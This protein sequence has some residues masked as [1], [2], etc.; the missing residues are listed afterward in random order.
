MSKASSNSDFASLVT[1]IQKPVEIP[2]ENFTPLLAHLMGAGTKANGF[3][4]SEIIPPQDNNSNEWR[5]VQR[6][7]SADKLEDWKNSPAR[8]EVL[9]VF[10]QS[11]HDDKSAQIC[12]EII[13]GEATNEV[14]T[15]IFTDLKP[16]MEEEYFAWELKMQSTQAA[17]PGYLGIHI[18]P[19]TSER[20]GRWATLLRFRSPEALDTWFSSPE[21]AQLLDEKQRFV[22]ATEI[23]KVD[24]SFPGWFAVD[25]KGKSPPN[26][27]TAQLVLLGIFPIVML[28]IKFCNP[29]YIEL[30]QI[31]P[32]IGN[33]LNMMMSCSLVA[34]V[35]MPQFIKIF[36]FWLYPPTRTAHS[37]LM[38]ELLVLTVLG[39]EIL[40]LWKLL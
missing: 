5:L 11:L 19:P 14:A 39:I 10:E 30:N 31:S 32:A 35:T 23:Q 37:E 16:G 29:H 24:S 21:R 27:K 25:S 12:E 8:K 2:L 28:Q 33:L 18:R 34:W 15:A 4:S 20:P 7:N 1:K 38:G 13:F 3:F 17:F 6:F 9:T 36:R 40:L 26:W 22:K